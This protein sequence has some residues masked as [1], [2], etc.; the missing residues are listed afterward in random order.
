MSAASIILINLKIAKPQIFTI[1]EKYFVIRTQAA[2]L[3]K[4]PREKHI[5][6]VFTLCY[7][8]SY[9]AISTLPWQVMIQGAAAR[10]PRHLHDFQV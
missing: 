10:P 9:Q 8:T 4:G 5:S 2:S 3:E 6:V 1:D 7:T